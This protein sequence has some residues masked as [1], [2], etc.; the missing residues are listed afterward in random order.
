MLRIIEMHNYSTRTVSVWL[1]SI[2]DT[3]FFFYL[4]HLWKY[5]ITKLRDTGKLVTTNID[6]HTRSN[7]AV[8]FKDYIVED[9]ELNYITEVLS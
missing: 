9:S 4:L 1:V 6:R 2:M 5:D 8:K 3:L 7:E